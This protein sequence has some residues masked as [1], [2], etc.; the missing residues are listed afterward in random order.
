M[1]VVVDRVYK[2]VRVEGLTHNEACWTGFYFARDYPSLVK[3][4]WFVVCFNTIE[5]KFSQDEQ[6]NIKSIWNNSARH[7]ADII[8]NPPLPSIHDC[9]GCEC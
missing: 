4:K 8:N 6:Y 2:V 5:E 3:D 1:L 9:P 7:I